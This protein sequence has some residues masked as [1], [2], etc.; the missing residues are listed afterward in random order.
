MN[1]NQHHAFNLYC[2]S[3]LNDLQVQTYLKF[4]IISCQFAIRYFFS[5]LNS[6]RDLLEDV[7]TKL[8][9]K[10]LFIGAFMSA[11]NNNQYLVDSVYMNDVMMINK[12]TTSQD[13]VIEV[14][15]IHLAGHCIFRKTILV[16]SI[17]FILIYYP[18]NVNGL[19]YS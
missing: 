10:G 3:H 6:I 16:R 1:L 4:S 8:K 9:R 14:I 7:K 11:N 12:K 19:V 13:C 18:E 17:W 5:D 2:C 15:H